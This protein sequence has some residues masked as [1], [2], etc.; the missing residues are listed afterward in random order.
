MTRYIYIYSVV[1]R[2]MLGHDNRSKGEKYLKKNTQ[3]CD[4][5]LKFIQLE[6]KLDP[7]KGDT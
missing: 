5:S 6:G 2:T 3:L 7:R 1:L 4:K